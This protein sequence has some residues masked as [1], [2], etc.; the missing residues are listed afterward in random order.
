VSETAKIDKRLFVNQR[1]F[2]N[3]L[4]SMVDLL[5]VINP[6][7]TVQYVNRVTLDV[8]GYSMEEVEGIPAGRLFDDRDLCFFDLLRELISRGEVKGKGLYMVSREGERI[9]VVLNGSL[10]KGEDRRVDGMIWVARDMRDIHQLITDLARTNEELEERVRR[11][12]EELQAAK[13]KSEK[14]FIELQQA[15]ALMVQSEKMASIG[16]LAAGI[17]HEINNPIGFVGSNLQALEGYIKDLKSLIASYDSLLRRCE[18]IGDAEI[19]S[20]IRELDQKREEIDLAFILDDID[21]IFRE[22]QEGVKRIS[23]IVKDLREFSHA[24]SDKPEYADLNKG[25]E[26]TLNIV[27][28]ELKYKAE[29][30]TAYGHIPQ[31]LCYPQQINQVFMNILV[32]AAQAIEEK[33]TI[34]VKTFTE[35]DYVVVEI[36]DTGKGIPR[37]NLSRIFDPFFTTKPVGKGTGLGL[38]IAYSIVRK[39]GG[40]IK[41][42]SEV[43]KGSSF[44][45]YM[46]LEAPELREDNSGQ[47]RG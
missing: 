8:L 39:H 2:E 25:L 44:K 42:E 11:R 10:I 45:I 7:A 34:W 14:A 12:T 46:P 38:A 26:S 47:R 15:Q 27:W 17:A 35:G 29:V 37:E 4:N 21:E 3:I 28:N 16:Q 6:D 24:G 5:I 32:N 40:E 36:G 30:V 33:G 9:P 19:V 20:S 43:G 18:K 41:V 23:K 31:I 22:T 13:E 1:F